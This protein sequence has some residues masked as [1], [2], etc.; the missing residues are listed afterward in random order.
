MILDNVSVSIG[1][2]SILE[3]VS[4]QFHDN[5]IN[6]I[7]GPSGCG[8]STLLKIMIGLILPDS[9]SVGLKQGQEWVLPEQ[10]RNQIGMVFQDDAL[11]SELTVRENAKYFAELRGVA[12]LEFNTVFKHLS[13]KMEL[14]SFADRRLDQLSGGQ[15]KRANIL[16]GLVHSP[17]LIIMDEPTTSLD[18]ISR[19]LIWGLVE[20]LKEDEKTVIFTT[21]YLEEAEVL[22]DRIIIMNQGRIAAQGTPDDLKQSI[23]GDKLVNLVTTPGDMRVMTELCNRLSALSGVEYVTY[24]GRVLVVKTTNASLT[25]RFIS[26]YLKN[27]KESIEFL[28]A[29]EPGLEDVF[30]IIT[31]KR[32][33]DIAEKG[34]G[35]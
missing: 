20:E 32:G 25:E 1:G 34:E 13:S 16:V 24:S 17:S 30:S 21:H 14:G 26:N 33:I 6:S 28:A 5:S 23:A 8:K 27:T 15:V 9:G 35:E 12:N 29:K 10:F 7:L 3:N 31:G 2:K 22:S 11:F 4:L 19:K 18:P